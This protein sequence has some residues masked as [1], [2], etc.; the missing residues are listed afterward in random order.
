MNILVFGSTESSISSVRPEAE[1]YLGLARRGHN[2]TILTHGT[3]EYAQRYRDQGIEVIDCHPRSKLSLSTI[4]ELRRLLK[5]SNFDIVYAT[6][7]KTISVA[8]FACI[9][10]PVK[11]VAYRGTTSGLYRHDPSSYL[12]VLHPRVDAVICVSDAVKDAVQ[13]QLGNS[14]KEC[15][16]IHKGHDLSWYDKSPASLEE[17]GIGPKDFTVICVINARPSKGLPV[18]LEATHYL[19]ELPHLHLLLVGRNID[20]TAYR[21][22]ISRSP[23]QERIHIAGYRHDAP[24]LIAASDI[25]VQPS[26]SGEG[27]P[28]TVMESLGYGTPTVITTTGGGKEVIQD[29]VNGFIVPI[30]D[31]RAIAER[32]KRLYSDPQL[33]QKLSSECRKTLE[34]RFSMDST[35]KLYED[36]F[37]SLVE[38]KS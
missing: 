31:P 28:R 25:L 7:S 38:R 27:L 18:M 34:G 2:L 24:E 1:I 23:M 5:S 6:N 8:G 15:V 16:T 30:K 11:L 32:V 19:A 21:E 26:I 20:N 17:F 29:G 14:R 35:I 10:L 36:Y 33:V 3:S 13:K 9:G 22:Q 12:S 4:F 37:S